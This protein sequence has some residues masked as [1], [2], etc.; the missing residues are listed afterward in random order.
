MQ[1]VKSKFA[2]KFLY[3]GILI[4]LF[5]I[6]SLPVKAQEIVDKT[7]ATVSD[8]VGDP[9]LITYSDLLWELALQPGVPLTPPTSEDL[10]FALQSLIDQRLFALEARRIPYNEP[11]QAEVKAEIQRIVERF[12][13]PAEFQKRLNIV[14]FDS[15]SDDNFQQIIERRV[16]I[17]KY[18][19]FRF[20]SF[21]VIT[22]EDELRY[23]RE[24]YTPQF[25]R[26]NPGLL[27]PQLDEVRERIRND[28]TA[29]RVARDIER[30]LDEAER[31]ASVAILNEV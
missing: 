11:T 12:P 18:V 14:G 15:I 16:A 23:Y 2:N 25:R 1:S 28:L 30:F 19:D 31:R 7:V 26:D 29:E 9:E 20:E 4:S 5:F 22:P 8:G 17:E 10:N 24:V 3:L 6:F 13:S 27:L 21:V